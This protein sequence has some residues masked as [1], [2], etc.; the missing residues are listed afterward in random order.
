MTPEQR[1]AALEKQVADLT[2]MMLNHKHTGIDRTKKLAADPTPS[3]VNYI[4]GTDVLAIQPPSGSGYWLLASNGKA[5]VIDSPGGVA[6][7]DEF[8]IPVVS[9]SP[10]AAPLFTGLGVSIKFETPANLLWVWNGTAW[11]SVVLA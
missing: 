2:R 8:N 1:I 9:V 5:I 4:E 7:V 10:V 11:K 6:A 3:G